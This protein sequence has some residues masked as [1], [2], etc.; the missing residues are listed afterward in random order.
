MQRHEHFVR[1]AGHAVLTCQ[2]DIGADPSLSYEAISYRWVSDKKTRIVNIEGS[3]LPITENA[4]DVLDSFASGRLRCYGC[5]L[6]GE[7]QVRRPQLDSPHKNAQKPY[8]SRV[9]I[10]QEIVASR[11]VDVHQARTK[12]APALI[13]CGCSI[14][15]QHL[16]WVTSLF[17]SLR[18]QDYPYEFLTGLW[19][20]R[21]KTDQFS[22]L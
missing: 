22:P 20:R 13:L 9:C 5:C 17:A 8:W 11:R 15:R 21:L 6:A 14:F 16:S 18:H 19:I 10:V 2:P 3:L 12:P 4:Y 7:N 1:N